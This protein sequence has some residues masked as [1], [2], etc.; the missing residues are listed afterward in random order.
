M[1]AFK[2]PCLFV[3]AWLQIS[4]KEYEYNRFVKICQLLPAGSAGQ[5]LLRYHHNQGTFITFDHPDPQI[6]NF[7]KLSTKPVQN[8]FTLITQTVQN[9]FR[10][11][12]KLVLNQFKVHPNHTFQSM[13]V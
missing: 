13:P 1:T 5:V 3:T 6:T 12:S 9:Q 7:S 11:S 10:I 2:K 4:R 8:Q